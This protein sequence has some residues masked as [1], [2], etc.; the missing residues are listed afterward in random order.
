MTLNRAVAVSKLRG[1]EAALTMIEPLN[2]K[3]AG[4]FYFHGLRGALLK[5]LN[6]VDDARD[7]FGRAIALANSA[8][9]ANHIRQQLD[10]LTRESLAN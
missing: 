3:L 4:Y 6:R 9:E 5:Q 8:A 1:A 2:E 10:Q 7:A